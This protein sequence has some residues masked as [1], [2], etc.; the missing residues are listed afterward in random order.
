MGLHEVIEVA[1]PLAVP[2]K[3]S[4]QAQTDFVKVNGIQLAMIYVV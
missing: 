3:K 2:D 1:G 4:S